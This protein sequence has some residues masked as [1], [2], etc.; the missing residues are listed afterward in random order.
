MPNRLINETSP[1]LLQHAHNPVDWYPWGVEA[2]QKAKAEDK[3]IFLSCGYSACHWC[4]VM[5][6]ESFEDDETAKILNANFVPIKIDREERPDLDSIYMN[7]VVAM[8]GQGGWPMS[9]FLSPEGVPF[10]GGTYFPKTARYGMPA[11]SDLLRAIIT[12]WN[13]P[14][15][16][17]EL[18]AG[19]ER[20]LD[21]IRQSESLSSQDAPLQTPTLDQA[22]QG[23]QQS[24]DWTY[25]GWGRAPKFPQP[26]TIEFLIRRYVATHNELL[27][28]TITKTLDAMARGGMYDQLGGGFHRYATD[29]IWLIPHFEKMLYDNAQLTRVYLHAWQITRNDFYRRIVQETLDYVA[30]EMTDPRG[31]FY[32]TQ[33]ADSE[34][35]E[36]KF[37]VWSIEEIRAV[38]GDDT[39][40]F[41]D[42]YGVTPQGNF[43]GKNILHVT[44]DLD[45]VAAMHYVVENE[46]EQRLK[47]ARQKLFAV[48]EQ[49]VK[50]ARDEK[51]LT[52]WNGLML[53]AFAEAARVLQRDDYRAIAERNANF[54]LTG[55]ITEE[56]RLHRSWKQGDAR[57]N[58]Y[59]ED[60]ANLSE[61]LLALYE[62]TFDARW[63]VAARELANAMLAHF[64]DPRGGFFDT[65]DDHETLVT[66]PKDLQDNAVPSGNAMAVT[67]L[68][69]LNA[70]TGDNRYGDAAE[71]ALKNIQVVLPQAPLG[72]TQWLSALDF[73][74]GH[75][76]E[77]AIIGTPD[78][79]RELLKVVWGTYRPNQVVALHPADGH[80]PIPLLE[81]R[82]QRDSKA[83]AYVCQNF[84]CKLPV[85]EPT[86]LAQQLD[87]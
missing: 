12:A 10:Y 3:P 87:A 68:L 16:R 1:Y 59:L 36:G 20:V 24:F 35:H 5:R 85:T 9:M 67:V 17:E 43:E 69:K 79:A 55:M 63:F 28:K 56:N 66:R 54:L 14:R 76:K 46:I 53:A 27:L 44:R 37:Y 4:H 39:P 83:T 32:S 73:A 11:F 38:L 71:H 48:R 65:S 82:T 80:S 33:D 47:A 84:A 72:F 42:R 30:R 25:G 23:I 61:G 22:T 19:G 81:N 18:L 50:P 26:M 8:T 41:I 21:A 58:G 6:G 60:Y 40:I 62:T 51:V 64:A 49:R 86:A 7:A 74:L 34:G 31:G 45:V 52:A 78:T 2:L 15:R 13:A 75:P 77:I 57:L 70:F 29:E